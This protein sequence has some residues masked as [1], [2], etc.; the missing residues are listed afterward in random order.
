M[1]TKC[2]YAIISLS[3]TSFI[4]MTT[5]GL[6]SFTLPSIS[7]I[8]SGISLPFISF[9]GELNDDTKALVALQSKVVAEN[10][11]KFPPLSASNIPEE[12]IHQKELNSPVPH[13]I[14]IE[15]PIQTPVNRLPHQAALKE[16]AHIESL[17]DEAK[18][19]IE[20]FWEKQARCLDW[21]QHWTKVLKWNP[22]Y[23]EWFVGGKLNPCYNCL[24][25]HLKSDTKDKIAIL[26]EGERGDTVTLTY[27]ELSDLVNRFSNVLKTRGVKKGD[28]VAIYMPMIPEAV[29]AMLSCARIGA[30]HTVVFGGFS[31]EALR[32][33]I[34][35]A[36]AELVITADGGFRRGSIISLKN[37][38]DEAVQKCPNVKN[39]IVVKH[40]G[41]PIN[42]QP[43]RDFWYASLMEEAAPICVPEIMDAED[44]LFILYT[45]GTTGK[46]KGIIHTCGGYMVGVTLTTRWVFDIKPSDVYWCTAD[47]GWITGHSYVVYGPLSN[48][49]SQFIYEGAPDWPQR[50]R[51]W[52]LID[53]YGITILY[54]APTAIRTF[55]K[56]GPEWLEKHDLSSLRLLGSVGEPINPEAWNW[57]HK[58]VGNENCPIVDTWWQTE[59][60]SIMIAPIP[61]LTP[62]K[63]G[64]AT[65][66]LPGIEA[67]VLNLDGSHASSGLLAITT[68]WPSMLRGINNDPKRFEQT[69]W[70]KWEG[71]YYFTGDG[72]TLDEDGY[73]WLTGRSDDVI[74]VS[75]HRLGSAEIESALVDNPCV[76]EAAAIGI[77]DAIKGQ[78]I[79]TFV[80]VKEGVQVDKALEDTL[81]RHVVRKIGALARPEKI[82][83][84]C[85]L[86]KTRSGKIMR[87]LLRDIAEGRLVGDTTTLSDP[88][89]IKE[90]KNRYED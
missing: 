73:F 63:P 44:Q 14:E 16:Y 45:S 31:A 18:Q 42:M 56:W 64:S 66:P 57:Y 81:K 68:P 4:F 7:V 47:V 55:M 46:P 54:T 79:V 76:A 3:V 62:L 15:K 50:D 58:Y 33:R 8:L 60:G 86:P 37:A 69:Y 2:K 34:L 27:S 43:D 9:Q 90:I 52:K 48:G 12:L 70:S 71:K 28:K 1:N 20:T 67:A 72:A 6:N 51:F 77:D 75:G 5:M 41:Q 29:I 17:F 40:A 87:R 59:T 74:K 80:T 53:K 88:E 84:I 35:D 19:D 23:A 24:D 10:I 39:V 21:F 25:R 36:D 89:V 61:G 32:D 65:K 85:E 26:W 83:F 82:I 78:S 13:N 30:V 11:E 38:V 22:P 49:M